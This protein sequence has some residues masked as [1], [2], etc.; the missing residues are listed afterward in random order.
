MATGE[1]P[2]SAAGAADGDQQRG[3]RRGK[4]Q[5]KV[6]TVV[7]NRMQKTV[8]VEVDG[9]AMHRL[10]RR[11]TRRT[12]KFAAH[13][14]KNE[15]KVGDRVLLESTRPLSKSKRWRVREILKRA[16]ETEP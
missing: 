14:E 7:S 10:Y 15:A 5:T 6:G 13:D 11:Q 4:S 12:S 1:T 16:E 3:N 9:T 2:N 8:L